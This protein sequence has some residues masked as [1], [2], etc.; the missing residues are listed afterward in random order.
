MDWA[1][2]S[3]ADNPGSLVHPDPLIHTPMATLP[4]L[5]APAAALGAAEHAVEVF[6]GGR[7]VL[8]RRVGGQLCGFSP[9]WSTSSVSQGR[10]P[11]R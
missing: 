7:R 6:K 5:V 3:A 4:N 10:W 1:L 8:P 2:L 9:A 11:R